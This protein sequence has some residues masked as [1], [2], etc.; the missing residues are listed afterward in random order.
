MA[1]DNKYI[2]TAGEQKLLEALANPENYG[3]SVTAL[4]KA[5]G[6]TRTVYYDAMKKPGFVRYYNQ[7]MLDLL[8]SK[9]GDVLRA[10]LKYA[11]ECPQNHQDRK[12]VCEMT[13]LYTPK[14]QQEIS[15]PGGEP[16]TVNIR[17]IE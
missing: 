12:M 17:V 8:K 6:V 3:K 2:P 5:A 9:V 13:G 1:L 16:F 14:Q 11:I 7:V 4:C 10:T 15:G